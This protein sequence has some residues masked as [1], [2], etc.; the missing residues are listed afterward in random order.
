MTSSLSLKELNVF[1]ALEVDSIMTSILAF[2]RYDLVSG[3]TFIILEN[4]VPIN[5]F[6]GVGCF[7]IC[8]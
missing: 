6:F 4:P 2:F 8:T 7:D 5:N 1:Q 3:L